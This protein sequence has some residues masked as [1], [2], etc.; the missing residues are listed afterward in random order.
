MRRGQFLLKLPLA[1]QREIGRQVERSLSRVPIRAG[2][3]DN[4]T[5][6]V[7]LIKPTASQ[8][9]QPTEVA[10]RIASSGHNGDPLRELLAVQAGRRTKTGK[11]SAG[12]DPGDQVGNQPREI[13]A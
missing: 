12:S 7:Q 11:R 3:F 4:A 9:N 6:Q 2:G 5:G 13:A 1:Q 10:P 8:R